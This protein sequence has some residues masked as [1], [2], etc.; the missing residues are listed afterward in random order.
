[1]GLATRL[2][3]RPVQAE[4]NPDRFGAI[5]SPGIYVPA[6]SLSSSWFLLASPIMNKRARIG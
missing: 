1:M 5:Y 6:T 2:A 4:I 3:P